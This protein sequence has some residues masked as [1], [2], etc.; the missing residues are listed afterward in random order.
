MTWRVLLPIKQ[1]LPVHEHCRWWLSLLPFL[2]GPERTLEEPVR[3][4]VLWRAQD[5]VHQLT[6]HEKLVVL[7]DFVYDTQ[8]PHHVVKLVAD[9]WLE[10]AATPWDGYYVSASSGTLTWNGDWG[11]FVSLGLQIGVSWRVVVAALVEYPALVAICME[12]AAFAEKGAS[13]LGAA[14]VAFLLEVCAET[15]ALR[16]E[17]RVHAH[18]CLGSQR[19]ELKLCRAALS[20]SP[21]GTPHKSHRVAALEISFCSGFGG[22]YYLCAPQIGAVWSNGNARACTGSGVSPAWITTLVQG[23][24]MGFCDTR[25]GMTRCSNGYQRRVAAPKA[26]EAGE[27]EI[28]L[29]KHVLAEQAHHGARNPAFHPCPTADA[30]FARNTQSCLG[31]KE[32]SVVE[33]PSRLG[34]SECIEAL[35]GERE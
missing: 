1:Y 32:I 22:C 8:P 23:E 10:V 13:L 14:R 15:G 25:E 21:G 19:V 28:A 11:I 4:I 5:G 27:Q 18:I 9:K 30:Q 34:K 29:Q 6:P 26:R 33:G 17:V 24:K 35:V 12:F 31:R 3:V 2:Q 20:L 7:H 16:A